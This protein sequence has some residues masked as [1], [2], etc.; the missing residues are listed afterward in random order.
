MHRHTP[1]QPPE[2]L[3][4]GLGP[5]TTL[6]E[7]ASLRAYCCKLMVTHKDNLSQST[8]LTLISLPVGHTRRVRH[9]GVSRIWAESLIRVC[10]LPSVCP[11]KTPPI[12]GSL[13]VTSPDVTD[14][15]LIHWVLTFMDDIYPAKGYGNVSN[16]RNQSTIQI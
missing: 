2:I 8:R 4:P 3:R 6:T 7:A 15:S 5:P 11:R 16:K 14:D 12:R 1:E 10:L 13:S 9:T